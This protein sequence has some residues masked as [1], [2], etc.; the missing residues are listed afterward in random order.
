VKKEAMRELDRLAKMPV[1]AGRVHGVAHRIS[2]G[3]SR[4]PWQKRTDEVIDLQKTKQVLDADHSGLEK[5]KDRILEV[6]RVRKLNPELKGPIVC[7]AGP[8]GSRQDIARRDRS[9]S[10]SVASSCG[11]ARRHA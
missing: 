5:P 7:F 2:T 3:W 10:R 1:A 9:R 6:P 8:P 4:L 11:V